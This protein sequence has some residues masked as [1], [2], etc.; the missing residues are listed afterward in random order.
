MRPCHWLSSLALL[1]MRVLWH[2]EVGAGCSAEFEMF[3]TP[4]D[5]WMSSQP[6]MEVKNLL[7]IIQAYDLT[8]FYRDVLAQEVSGKLREHSMWFR[9]AQHF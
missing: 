6:F 1:V 8:P 4:H 2:L 9:A 5:L 3:H 7:F